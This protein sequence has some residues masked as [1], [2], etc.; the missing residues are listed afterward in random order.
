MGRQNEIVLVGSDAGGTMTDMLVVDKT[1]D[2]VV[3]KASTTPHDESIGF[4]E[5]LADAFEY[6][7][8]DWEK[9]AKDVLPGI[10]AFVYS[11]TAML[12]AL[13]TRTGKKVGIIITKGFED[14]LLHERGGGIHAGYGYQDKLHFVTHIHNEP[15][16]PKRLIRGVTERV[17][18]FGEAVIPLYEDETR[19]AV[20]ELIDRGVEGIAI[21]FLFSYLNPMNEMRARELAQE[22]M[23]EK[24]VEI[25]LYL[26]YEIVPIT[27][28]GP[29]LNALVLQAYGAEPARWQLLRIEEKLRDKGYKYP[30]Q[31]M[32]ADGGIANIKYP[33][34][35][36][37]CFSGPVGGVLGGRYLSQVMDMPNLVCSDM[38]GTSF[39]VGLIMGGEPILLRE[40]E[41]GRA[42]LNIPTLVM[43]SIGAGNGQYLSI[44]PESSRVDIG[45]G[46][47]G[48]DPGPVSY[49]M[50]NNVPTVM[51]CMVI[52][53]ILNPDYYLGG[54]MKLRVDLALKAIKE[55]CADP[56]GV[57]P[58]EFAEGV[59][60][61]VNTRM[62]EH[63]STVLSVRG[64]SPADYHLIG[65]GG[66]GPMFLASYAEGMPFKG[67]FTVPWAAAFSAFGCTAADY[68][69]RRQKSTLVSIAP[70]ADE[71]VREYM[72][73]TVSEA[74]QELEEMAT[75]EMEEEGFKKEDI[76]FRQLAYV[77]YYQQLEDVEV[78]S[79]ISRLETAEDM[80]KL[81]EAFEEVYSRKYTNAAKFPELGYQ[82]FEVGL[83]AMV[84][85][86]KP[87]LR[88]YPL[89]DKT[90]AEVT[91]KGEREVYNGGKWKKARLYEM[92]M[93]ESGNE[94]EGLA[95]IEAPSTTMFVP[96]GKKVVIDEFKR[97]WL[98]EV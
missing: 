86:I 43:D 16:V 12:N 65:Y 51:D 9:E 6:W 8:M 28:E 36:K 19:K 66:A 62:K 75:R 7:D 38:G 81:I 5:S 74:W 47:A 61:L 3:G 41:L 76:T 82:I 58:Y 79:P 44:D 13:L 46:S 33:A 31:I 96:E 85:K 98:Q 49:N 24:G 63:I 23:E 15:F 83:L 20:G 68:V 30:L 17:S 94:V 27:R 2:F 77:R 18:M 26:S 59:V 57:D 84:P 60:N 29:R 97:F 71:A 89:K 4:I 56:I 72:A 50:G 95:I 52:M 22:V 35:F 87:E 88:K 70:D 91:F 39:D 40:V 90:P 78:F 55:Q 67:V 48:A 92:D 11:G 80:D 93:L 69:H 53:G 64:Y 10:L 25:P 21:L 14:S 32:L 54:K 73:A 42:V 1:G 45:P 37:A 34:L